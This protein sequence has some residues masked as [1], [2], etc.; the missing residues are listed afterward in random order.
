MDTKSKWISGAM[1]AVAMMLG[2]CFCGA[3]PSQTE[4]SLYVSDAANGA[5]VKSPAFTENGEALVAKC[6]EPDANDPTVCTSDLLV[7]DAGVHTIT[8]SAEGY[9]P[10]TVTVDTSNMDSVHLAVELSAAK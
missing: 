1:A 2:G 10:Q 9:A 5:S 7:L 8:V 4:A 3:G 6:G